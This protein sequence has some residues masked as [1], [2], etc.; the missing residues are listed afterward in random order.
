MGGQLDDLSDKWF[1]LAGPDATGQIPLSLAL[2]AQARLEAAGGVE[3]P[4]PDQTVQ[5]LKPGCFMA[6]QA[7][8]SAVDVIVSSKGGD[9][10]KVR[11]CECIRGH[12]GVR[13]YT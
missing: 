3:E 13:L 11:T 6:R 5:A 8:V 1:T 9:Q 7:F 4:T 10:A 2:R 12:A